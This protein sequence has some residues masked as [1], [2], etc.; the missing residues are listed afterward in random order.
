MNRRQLFTRLSTGLVGVC[1]ATQIPTSWLPKPVRKAAATW[2]LTQAF[3]A[4]AK[5]RGAAHMPRNLYAS[6]ALFDAFQSEQVQLSRETNGEY[7][8]NGTA[9]S[10]F[11]TTRL[12]RRGTAVTGSVWEVQ[13]PLLDGKVL[14]YKG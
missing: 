5:G 6:P 9:V 10:R 7:G 11:K 14:T 3:N 1:V 12:H 4:A 2:F 13:I 8:L